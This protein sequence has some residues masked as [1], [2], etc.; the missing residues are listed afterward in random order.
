MRVTTFAEKCGVP[1]LDLTEFCNLVGIVMKN[2]EDGEKALLC[3][4]K[5]KR[6]NDRPTLQCV[7]VKRK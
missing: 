7:K 3:I 4:M 2:D 1:V 6:P 5:G